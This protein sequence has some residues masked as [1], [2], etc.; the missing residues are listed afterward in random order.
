MVKEPTACQSIAKYC[1]QKCCN[2][3]TK[4]RA[5]CQDIDCPLYSRRL[6][7]EPNRKRGKVRVRSEADGK[8]LPLYKGRKLHRREI[9]AVQGGVFLSSDKWQEIQKL[10]ERA[11]NATEEARK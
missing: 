3:S 2:G 11:E 5:E 4:A 6:A 8:Y 7:Q 10:I 1:L 9:I